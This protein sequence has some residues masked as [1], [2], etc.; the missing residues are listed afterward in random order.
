ML[1]VL[2]V[3]VVALGAFVLVQRADSAP[4]AVD[5]NQQ[6]PVLLIPGYGG[7]TGSLRALAAELTQA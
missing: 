3:A 1:T 6:G 5:Q 4:V 2:V 7:S